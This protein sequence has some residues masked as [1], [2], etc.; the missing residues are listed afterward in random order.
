MPLLL[1]ACLWHVASQQPHLRPQIKHPPAAPQHTPTHLE[2]HRTH[3]CLSTSQM[4]HA[5]IPNGVIGAPALPRG[6]DLAKIC[7]RCTAQAQRGRK[8]RDCHFRSS[9]RVH[10][11]RGAKNCEASTNTQGVLRATRLW[12]VLCCDH[13]IATVRPTTAVQTTAH[14]SHASW[15]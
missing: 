1:S 6:T 11:S 14:K 12:S 10:N 5:L 9:T 4:Q 13:R 3:L 7:A 2:A 8:A 15:L